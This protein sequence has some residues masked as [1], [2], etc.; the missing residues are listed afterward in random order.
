M[1]SCS[2]C[3]LPSFP[4][5]IVD[6]WSRL[7]FTPLD[8]GCVFSTVCL[9]ISSR[10]RCK[11]AL[12]STANSL[13]YFRVSLISV[14]VELSI[15]L[16][17]HSDGSFRNMFEMEQT[18]LFRWS[19]SVCSYS[20][21]ARLLLR[22]CRLRALIFMDSGSTRGGVLGDRNILHD[23]P[24]RLSLNTLLFKYNP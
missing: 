21:L 11:V 22:W 8:L 24:D 7:V 20:Y 15:Y 10:N 1:R 6:F 13:I 2:F 4:F 16:W 14:S 18:R 19:E 9:S 23:I 3:W 5:F 12:P 17:P